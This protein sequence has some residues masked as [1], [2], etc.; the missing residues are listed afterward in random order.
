MK[1]LLFIPSPRDIPEFLDAV[2]KLHYDKYWVKYRTPEIYAYLEARNYFLTH[3][4]Y[5]HFVLL[6]DDLIVTE[7]DVSKL[8]SY[9]EKDQSLKV[10]SGFCNIDTTNL[11]DYPNICIDEISDIREKRVYKWITFQQ[12]EEHVKTHTLANGLVKVYFSGFPLMVIA[13]E[14]LEKV[15]FRNDSVDGLSKN[16]CCTD[17][18]FCVDVHRAGFEIFIDPKMR[19]KHLKINDGTFQN[20]GLNIKEP[21]SKLEKIIN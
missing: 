11:K 9:V 21:Y 13:R 20:M 17:V 14:V 19:L 16:G 1:P 7:D 5:T 10:V 15:K 2:S 4:E 18:T 12:L 8:L 6:P 3:E